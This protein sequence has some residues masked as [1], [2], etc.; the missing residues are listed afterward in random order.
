MPLPSS[1]ACTYLNKVVDKKAIVTL[2][3]GTY[4][5]GLK[6]TEESKVTLLAG[7]YVIKDGPLTV[8]KKSS[9]EGQN[10][11]FYF[12]GDKAGLL[13]DKDSVVS[14]T[15]PRDGAMSGLLFAE[16]RGVVDPAPAPTP[17]LDLITGLLPPLPP[18]L[19]SSAPKM[20]E[21]R[22][23]SDNARVLLGTIYLPSGRLIIDSTKPV[24]DRSAY[25]VIVVRRLDL[26]DGPNLYLNSDYAASDIPVPDGVGPVG[27]S[28]ALAQ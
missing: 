10:V 28:A 12:S 4:C 2:M 27:G 20:R 1:R 16:E 7:T 19:P 18:L 15:A 17:E 5:G 25:T 6:V 24:S 22:I 8:N 13:F 11:G 14:L 26:F 3:P 9:F 23:I 21:Y